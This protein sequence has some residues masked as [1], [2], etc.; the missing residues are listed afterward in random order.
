MKQSKWLTGLFCL[1]AAM[2]LLTAAISVPILWRSFYYAHVGSLEQS[3]GLSGLEIRT[4]FDEMMDYCIG[5]GEFST[6]TL[7]WSVSGKSHF[8]DVRTLFH[9]DLTVLALSAGGLIILLL[10]AKLGLWRPRTL[11]GGGPLFWTGMGISALLFAAGGLVALDFD[12]AFT[13]FHAL[14]FPGKDNWLFDPNTDQIIIILPQAFFLHCAV[15]ILAVL[16]AECVLC[17]S[18][19]R[20]YHKKRC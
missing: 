8:S 6:G 3:T 19:D 18:A 16:L 15:L 4:A 10:T 2:A 17:M 20:L 12:R 1:L 9:L 13:L 5:T 7:A 11:W 14:F